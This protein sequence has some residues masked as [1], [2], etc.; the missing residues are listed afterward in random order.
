MLQN[1]ATLLG[2][3]Y[4]IHYNSLVTDILDEAE[5]ALVFVETLTAVDAIKTL[6]L[7]NG[8]FVKDKNDQ[9]TYQLA[10]TNSRFKLVVHTLQGMLPA[11][12]FHLKDSHLRNPHLLSQ[13]AISSHMAQNDGYLSLDYIF[14]QDFKLPIKKDDP[15]FYDKIKDLTLEQF[16]QTMMDLRER[17]DPFDL[18]KAEYSEAEKSIKRKETVY[19]KEMLGVLSFALNYPAKHLSAEDMI[20]LQK[21]FTPLT[22][23]V[24][25]YMPQRSS[26]ELLALHHSGVLQI[27]AVNDDSKVEADSG[28]G[29]TYYYNNEEGQPIRAYFETYIDCIGQPDIPLEDFPFKTPLVQKVVSPAL[30]KFRSSQ[31][32]RNAMSVRKDVSYLNEYYYLKVSGIAIHDH[33]KTVDE[34]GCSNNRIYMMA[35]PYIGGYNPDYSGLDFYDEAAKVISK[36]LLGENDTE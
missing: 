14:D 20:R 3:P 25:A 24:I 22:S 35:V 16:V 12:R 17:I 1:K 34:K 23:I 8:T 18:L 11:V 31:E 10:N 4:T 32:G 30:L 13:E 26:E 21:W 2:I 29:A 27:I 9:L 19:W 7:R 28:G 15:A 33:F 6:A 5:T 36:S